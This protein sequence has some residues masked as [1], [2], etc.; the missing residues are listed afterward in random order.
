MS[1]PLDGSGLLGLAWPYSDRL[2]SPFQ[3]HE[4]GL[5]IPCSPSP[6]LPRPPLPFLGPLFSAPPQMPSAAPVLST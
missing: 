5:P 3:V 2:L 1:G 6:R 4:S